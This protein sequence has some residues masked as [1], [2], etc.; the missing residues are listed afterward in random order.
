MKKQFENYETPEIEIV[1][2][3]VEK[4][5]ATTGEGE[6]EFGEPEGDLGGD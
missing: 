1:V 4:G 3:N 6:G 5:F 2:I